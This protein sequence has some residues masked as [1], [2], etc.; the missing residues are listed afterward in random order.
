MNSYESYEAVIGLEV[1]VELK[2][3]TKIFC[4]C[5]TSFGAPPNTHVCPVCMGLP[6]TLPVLNRKAVEFAIKAGL[7]LE[8]SIQ[9]K[10]RLDRKNYFYP[11]L[12]KAYQISQ[13]ELPLCYGGKVYIDGN[14]S[15]GITRIHIEEDAG[16]LIHDASHGTMIDYNR[17]GVPLI[18]IVSEPDIRSA[19]EAKVY[20]GELRT[21]LLYTGISDC[22][23]DEGSLRCDVNLSV[24][25][26]GDKAFGV[27]TEMKNINSFAF[28]AKAIEYEFSRQAELIENGDRVI[29]E[30]RR[31]DSA[32]GKTYSMRSKETAADYRFFPEPDI[33]SFEI[34][35]EMIEKLRKEIP[36]LPAERRQRYVDRFGLRQEDADIIVSRPEMADYFEMVSSK[37]EFTRLAANMMITDLLALVG[38]D[39]FDCPISPSALAELA[40]L[41]G[42][43]AVNSSTVKKL[44]KL[45]QTPEYS[46]SSPTD[47]VSSLKLYQ[48]ND[49]EALRSV[50]QSVIEKSPKLLTDYKSGKS[51]AK[52]AIIGGVMA[53]TSGLANPIILNDIFDEMIS[54]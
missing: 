10:T 11:D 30:T 24:R 9:R 39:G 8:C 51:S 36:S 40:T 13:Y 14:K 35:V 37:T 52:K 15:I 22:R 1:H 18:E 28:V 25:K 46:G 41:S 20:L 7:A 21:I 31:F 27:R 16:K 53:H 12:P 32:T 29:P 5:P 34:S 47:I 50:L 26:K 2:T 43:Q 4:S 17:C 42:S 38:A 44:I 6:G 23:M 54:D 48:I 3:D 33:P 45:L 49:L 19:E